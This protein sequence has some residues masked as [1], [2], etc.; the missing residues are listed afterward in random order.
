M[1]VTRINAKLVRIANNMALNLAAGPGIQQHGRIIPDRVL[2]AAWHEAEA[3]HAA[4][5]ELPLAARGL[6]DRELHPCSRPWAWWHW[7]QCEERPSHGVDEALRLLALGELTDREIDTAIA[8]AERHLDSCGR[9]VWTVH[10]GTNQTVRVAEELI[11]LT[12][13]AQLVYRVIEW[14]STAA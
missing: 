5:V 8:H 2:E 7:T 9:Q 14:A 6:F 4:G 1:T 10:G 12:G 3:A 13:R 11:A